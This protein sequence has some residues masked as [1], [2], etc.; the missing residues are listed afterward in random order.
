[1]KLTPSSTTRR[2][3]AMACSRLGGSPQIPDPVIRIAPKPMRLTVRSPPTSMVPAAAAVG[4]ALTPYL[5]KAVPD[6]T[7]PDKSG[8][9]IPT[10]LSKPLMD[11]SAVHG[12]V[13]D[14]PGLADDDLA[15]A[16]LHDQVRLEVPRQ[17]GRGAR[18]PARQLLAYR[19]RLEGHGVGLPPGHAFQPDRVLSGPG[20]AGDPDKQ[21]PGPGNHDRTIQ[22]ARENNA[23]VLTCRAF[24]GDREFPAV[25][26]GPLRHDAQCGGRRLWGWFR[27]GWRRGQPHRAGRRHG[28]TES[29]DSSLHNSPGV[30]KVCSPTQAGTMMRRCPVRGRD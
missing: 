30:S 19:D 12:G 23:G 29:G 21:V 25:Q 11:G 9:I 10:T 1:M 5:L 3:V 14:E 6:K 28:G 20:F 17:G 15:D 22:Q 2:S 27:V 13:P 4:C 7:K 8:P 24:R 26:V 16:G 18:A